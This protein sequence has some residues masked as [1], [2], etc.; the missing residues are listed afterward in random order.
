MLLTSRD[1]VPFWSHL[2]HFGGSGSY[3]F[4]LCRL[5]GPLLVQILVNVNGK[6]CVLSLLIDE[7]K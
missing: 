7:L 6:A 4:V 5:L 3:V 2:P 1:D